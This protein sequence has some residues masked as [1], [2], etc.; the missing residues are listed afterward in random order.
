MASD[1]VNDGDNAGRWRKKCVTG[2]RWAGFEMRP[3]SS[4][5]QAAK[6][7]GENE[8]V[9]QQGLQV[10]PESTRTDPPPSGQFALLAQRR[11]APFFWT[12]FC[13]AGNDNVFKF[14]FT[15][16]VTYQLT[17]GDAFLQPQL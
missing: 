6:H 16:M 10:A 11:F 13:G 7:D 12:Q 15:V 5:L 3:F 17:L 9:T 2:S 14:A 4:T 8:S 1:V